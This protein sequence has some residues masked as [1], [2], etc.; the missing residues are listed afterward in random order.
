M[1]INKTLLAIALN[2]ILICVSYAQ[3]C[4]I[5]EIDSEGKLTFRFTSRGSLEVTSG[6]SAYSEMTKE[7]RSL[8]DLIHLEIENITKTSAQTIIVPLL[9]KLLKNSFNPRVVL[10][11][12]YKGEYSDISSALTF[13]KHELPE[14]KRKERE[15]SYSDSSE[16]DYVAPEDRISWGEYL[17]DHADE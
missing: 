16:E 15:R 6:T 10:T 2:I 13:L 7:E 12:D 14:K 17:L 3:K 8:R 4:D 11:G 1:K 5:S 9:N